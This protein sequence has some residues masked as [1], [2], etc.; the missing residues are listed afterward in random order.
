[1]FRP[2]FTVRALMIGVALIALATWAAIHATTPVRPTAWYITAVRLNGRMPADLMEEHVRRAIS[3][4]LLRSAV[5]ESD[6]AW[7]RGRVLARGDATDQCLWFYIKTDLPQERELIA[8]IAAA[9]MRAQPS[10][11]RHPVTPLVP[12]DHPYA[13]PTAK[14]I[15]TVAILAGLLA[16][17]RLALR[18]FARAGLSPDLSPM[19]PTEPAP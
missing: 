6:P 4:E 16:V 18:R 2:R 19:A 12:P 9:Y 17:A 3:D 13:I 10:R 15:A 7:V 5:P 14:I 11:L 8:R 1:M